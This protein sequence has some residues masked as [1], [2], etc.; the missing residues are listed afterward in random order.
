MAIDTLYTDGTFT[1]KDLDKAREEDLKKKKKA[2]ATKRAVQ[3][4]ANGRKGTRWA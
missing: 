1:K 4:K 2:G 3:R